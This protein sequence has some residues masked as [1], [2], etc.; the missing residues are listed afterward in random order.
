MLRKAEKDGWADSSKKANHL[1]SS[2]LDVLMRAFDRFFNIDNL[3]YSTED[4]TDRDFYEEL[5][6]VRDTILRVLG[7]LEVAVP[8]NRRNAYWLLKF[9][10]T[11][12]LSAKGRDDHREDI[13]RQDT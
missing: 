12:L 8:E 6:T 2:E 10:E 1:L 7:I 3:E 5:V 11:K 9:D 4:L 13:Y